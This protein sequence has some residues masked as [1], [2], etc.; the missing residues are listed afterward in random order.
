MHCSQ[1]VKQIYMP[2]LYPYK[3]LLFILSYSLSV[4]QGMRSTVH[5]HIQTQSKNKKK[6]KNKF[7]ELVVHVRMFQPTFYA[8][9]RT[10][11]QRYSTS[12]Q[13]IQIKGTNL[14]IYPNTSY[15]ITQLY[16]S[17]KENLKAHFGRA[18]NLGSR[19]F[20]TIQLIN[21]WYILFMTN[22]ILNLFK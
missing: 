19:L 17:R 1:T 20:N 2:R 13:L 22:K 12:T 3:A 7:D 4:V 11:S 6:T 15:S 5:T 10:C 18:L 21:N 16:V 8:S 14:F 9:K